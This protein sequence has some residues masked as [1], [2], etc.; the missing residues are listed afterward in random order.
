MNVAQQKSDLRQTIHRRI[1]LYLNE[2]SDDAHDVAMGAIRKL[3]ATM[4]LA[5][6]RAWNS[7]LSARVEQEPQP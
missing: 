2:H 4:T 6:L 3:S 7:A 5:E 1:A